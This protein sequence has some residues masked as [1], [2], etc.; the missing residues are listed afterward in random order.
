MKKYKL[1]KFQIFL[2]VLNVGLIV[3]FLIGV[4]NSPAPPS[5][6]PPDVTD[7][8]EN[9]ADKVEDDPFY[10]NF[11]NFNENQ[12]RENTMGFLYFRSTSSNLKKL[13][14][15]SI[16]SID[17]TS[18]EY[19]LEPGKAPLTLSVI[20]AFTTE[21]VTDFVPDDKL[22]VRFNKSEYTHSEDGRLKDEYVYYVTELKISNTSDSDVEL[23][24]TNPAMMLHFLDKNGERFWYTPCSFF[25]YQPGDS[26]RNAAK[27]FDFKKGA[28]FTSKYVFVVP[29]AAL[30]Y[31]N[32]CLTVSAEGDT[33][34][35]PDYTA[36]L[37]LEN[38]NQN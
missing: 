5:T 1:T 24:M 2:I 29:R 16:K 12:T 17:K 31:F 32:C 38:P 13:Y 6:T 10:P 8:P 15:Q 34:C 21:E 9:E 3:Y 28:S 20:N 23:I 36:M 25:S 26:E 22:W 11:L 30:K 27:L 35:D 37:V 14:A 7:S 18:V 19:P 33:S 4:F